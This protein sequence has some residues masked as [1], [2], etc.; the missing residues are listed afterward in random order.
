MRN[1]QKLKAQIHAPRLA[2]NFLDSP[3]G[4][5]NSF[6]A[7]S[8]ARCPALQKFDHTKPTG[9]SVSTA[10]QLHPQPSVRSAKM[11]RYGVT[12]IDSAKSA[13]SRGSYL[14]V[15]FKN[16]REAAQAINGW[17]LERALQFLENV[18]EHKEA[19]PMRRYGGSTGRTPQGEFTGNKSSIY[20]QSIN[21]QI[22]TKSSL[23]AS[24][25]VLPELDG[26]SSLLNFSSISSKTP[27]QTPIARD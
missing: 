26:R 1:L 15:S 16:T 10:L 7:P 2:R 3:D 27:N 13:R 11:V 23:Q 21:E 25:S 12:S 22:L 18:K 5:K 6:S 8:T 4:R 24:N 9:I 20:D 19:V 14:R 17:K